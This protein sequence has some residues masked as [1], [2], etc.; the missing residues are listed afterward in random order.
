[1]KFLCG[2]NAAVAM[3]VCGDQ[4]VTSLGEVLA[5]A[6]E[7]ETGETLSEEYVVPVIERLS[8]GETLQSL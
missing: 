6:A 4:A 3:K 7:A 1:M 8:K 5:K 2:L